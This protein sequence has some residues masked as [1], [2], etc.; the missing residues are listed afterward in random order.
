LNKQL[1]YFYTTPILILLLANLDITMF[2]AASTSDINVIE[3]TSFI[4]PY[5]FNIY[6][7]NGDI[8]SG[9]ITVEKAQ[10]ESDIIIYRTFNGVS[11][12]EPVTIYSSPPQTKCY[13]PL[14]YNINETNYFF[15]IELSNGSYSILYRNYNTKT[16][17]SNI[18]TPVN[19]ISMSNDSSI[20][21]FELEYYND[22]L[23]LF[24]NK[25]TSWIH[26]IVLN[27]RSN[28]FSG[29]IPLSETDDLEYNNET[30]E[31]RG[32]INFIRILR[33]NFLIY[34]VRDGGGSAYGEL[35]M[36][37]VK[38]NF[39]H[40]G[41]I[42]I[43]WD[44]IN[45]E[46]YNINNPF[47]YRESIDGVLFDNNFF[48][49]LPTYPMTN[50]NWTIINLDDNYSLQ[51]EINITISKDILLK[52]V[53][54]PYG[55]K[56]CILYLG[57][58][59]DN[60]CQQ[61][62]SWYLPGEQM[63]FKEIGTP[64][65]YD[66]TLMEKQFKTKLFIS[67]NFI[68][69]GHDRYLVCNYISKVNSTGKYQF[70][71]QIIEKRS[72][73]V[74]DIAISQSIIY[75]YDLISIRIISLNGNNAGLEYYYDFGDGNHIERS[76]E[77][78]LIYYYLDDGYYNICVKA[79]DDLGFESEMYSTSIIVLNRPPNIYNICISDSE[80]YTYEVV[81]FYANISD[82][83]GKINNLTWTLGDNTTCSTSNGRHSY[84]KNGRYNITLHVI[85][86]DLAENVSTI[87]ITVFNRPPLANATFKSRIFI[88]ERLILDGSGSSDP[89]GRIVSWRWHIDGKTVDGQQV[90]H[91][92]K[93]VGKH[94]IILTV[95]DD[96]GAIQEKTFEISV[97]EVNMN[98]ITYN[99]M[100]WII[101]IIIGVVA[102]GIGAYLLKS[103][104]RKPR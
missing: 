10:N 20:S 94:A 12:S 2:N 18:F 98:T 31:C 91:S 99:W 33:N 30:N 76:N 38:L 24:F 19:N 101:I 72:V 78:S 87:Q 104:I 14:G 49:N 95:T 96:D 61:Y 27:I 73:P 4:N 36:W 13:S 89:D 15:W 53:M 97:M 23:F 83:D 56:L 63:D 82:F 1:Y 88:D 71:S 52:C 3:N 37:L 25:D 50:T 7:N 32:V 64:Y 5:I 90:N 26:L 69:N 34:Y 55:D 28:H 74:C 93:R 11:Y 42:D 17:Y 62:Y 45:I 67:L 16:G 35:P 6:Y 68:K 77:D 102:V 85:D 22:S 70:H 81:T 54:I 40:L 57:K 100:L 41:I 21:S 29:I 39:S 9:I 60:L 65:V 58:T 51:N 47:T 92:F 80:V 59:G 8:L 44:L 75:T 48:I 66:N 86:N 43:K 103:N 84:S 79:Q 46:Y